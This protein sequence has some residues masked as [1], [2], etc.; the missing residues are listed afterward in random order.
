MA[1]HASPDQIRRDLDD[2]LSKIN[3]LEVTAKDE[4]QTGV[5][6]ILRA[7]VQGQAHSL[8]EFGHLKKA[9]DL[10]TLEIFAVKGTRAGPPA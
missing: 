8:D 1:G 2:M 5:A 3:A 9:I 7:L 4:F 10:V 6:K